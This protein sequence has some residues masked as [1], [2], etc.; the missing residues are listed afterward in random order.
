MSEEKGTANVLNS[1]AV[2]VAGKT[3]TAQVAGKTSHAWFSGYFPYEK[4]R[5]VICVFLENGGP[6]YAATV[7]AKQIIEAMN[8]EGLI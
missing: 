8:N 6:G 1:L 3:G 7:I 2:K 5:F 4:P